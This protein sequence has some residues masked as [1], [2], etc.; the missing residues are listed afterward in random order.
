VIYE[1][2]TYQIST[3]S[4]NN[5][6]DKFREKINAR[7]KISKLGAFWYTEIGP[8]NEIIHVWP[9]DDMEHRN[10]SREQAIKDKVWPPD[11]AKYMVTMNTEFWKPVSFSPEWNER[12]IGPF[13]EMRIYTFPFNEIDKML[14]AWEKKID[15]RNKLAPL[16]GAFISEVG[17]VNKFM[18]IWAYKSLQHRTEARE[19]FASIGWPPKSEAK[20]PVKMENKIVLPSDFSPIQ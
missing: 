1:F 12:H 14:P 7:N 2:R 20:P 3:G 18:H 16:V 9:Y 11:S 5:V 19:K 6:L 8:L 17:D 10:R 4:L 15:D 13:F